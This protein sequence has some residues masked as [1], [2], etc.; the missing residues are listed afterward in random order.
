MTLHR[1]SEVLNSELSDLSYLGNGQIGDIYLAQLEDRP[2]V[3]KTTADDRDDLLI[4]AQMLQDLSKNGLRVPEVIASTKAALVLEYIKPYGNTGYDKESEAAK[5]IASLHQVSNE[6]RMYG[7][8][9]NTSIASFPQNN[10]QT[11]YN[12]GLFLSQM[13]IL[14]MAKLCYDRGVLEK[15]LLDRLETLCNGL[16]RR[17]DM[18]LITPS[19]LHGDIWSGNIIYE[20]SGVCFIDPAIYFGDKEM[21][22]AFIMLF[23]TF[24]E[25]FFDEYTKLHPLS[26]DFYETKVALYQIYPLL[27]HVAL[28]GGGYVS[29]LKQRLEILKV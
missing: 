18:S 17:I 5:A 25:R 8:Y 6:S 13:R 27:V 21:E 24:G 2:V 7:Y 29:E 10:E 12:W 1:L 26:E 9:Y 11:Q 22:L 19:L 23:H 3:I 28:Y 14:P 15:S 16:Y 4:E 20:K